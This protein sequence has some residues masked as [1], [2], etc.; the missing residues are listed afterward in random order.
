MNAISVVRYYGGGQQ[1]WLSGS[2]FTGNS[3]HFIADPA[4]ASALTGSAYN[5]PDPAGQLPGTQMPWWVEYQIPQASAPFPLT[6]DWK[7][8]SRSSQATLDSAE[9]D[10]LIVN[11]DPNDPAYPDLGS[12]TNNNNRVLNELGNV[13]FF[14]YNFGWLSS[15]P[16]SDL[17]TKTF[18]AIDGVVS[19]RIYERESGLGSALIDAIC[20]S[21]G[22]YAP[23]DSDF[24]RSM[25]TRLRNTDL[26]VTAWGKVLNAPGSSPGTKRF[27][28]T[29]GS[30]LAGGPTIT[31]PP[32]P[33]IA[34]SDNFN[35]GRDPAW[36]DYAGTGTSSVV[37]GKLVA[38]GGYVET[39]VSGLTTQDVQV[40]V[41]GLGNAPLFVML[42][43]RD[44]NTIVLPLYHSAWP[45]MQLYY[46]ENGNWHTTAPAVTTGFDNTSPVPIHG[47]AKFEGTVAT[48][49]ITDGTST[50]TQT[51]DFSSEITSGLV[52]TEGLVGL[53]LQVGQQHDNFIVST[54]S[55]SAITVPA[56]SV[57]VVIPPSVTGVPTI[58]VDDYV[59][60]VG[61]A[62]K[63]AAVAGSIRAV[64]IDQSSDIG[65]IAP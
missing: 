51:Y 53:Q 49:S 15:S 29:D 36:M 35:A 19:F 61:I 5:F 11:G 27:H 64:T 48:W 22:S 39:A 8:W 60:V 17:A 16:A 30:A 62:G 1:I 41:D 57:Q 45:G 43:Y 21:K 18:N 6:G 52:P 63:G 12:P 4:A 59:K 44:S 34:F 24:V 55:G 54:P 23:N 7:F 40:D 20:W 31:V 37:D 46:I 3:G 65:K 32:D 13:G 38:T 10:W 28:I 9:S 56:D 33:V 2:S 25:D 14:G 50:W 26:L 47:T 42:R 58:S